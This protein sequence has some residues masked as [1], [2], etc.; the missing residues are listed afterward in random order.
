M[1]FSLDGLFGA[2]YYT[3][4][5]HNS[6]HVD[7][8]NTTSG[9]VCHIELP[10]ENVAQCVAF[11]NDVIENGFI[12][13]IVA[14]SPDHYIQRW[15]L[16]PNAL[17]G[18]SEAQP[19][20]LILKQMQI[21]SDVVS[22]CISPDKTMIVCGQIDN[23][24]RKYN[25]ENGSLMSEKY[26]GNHVFPGAIKFSLDGMRLASSN[27]D[28]S[29]IVWEP[30]TISEPIVKFNVKTDNPGGMKKN[31]AHIRCIEFDPQ[32]SDVIAVGS[33]DNSLRIWD[34]SKNERISLLRHSSEVLCCSFRKDGRKIVTGSL[35]GNIQVWDIPSGTLMQTITGN[36]SKIVTVYFKTS[37]EIISA[38]ASG[39]IITWFNPDIRKIIDSRLTGKWSTRGGKRKRRKNRK[40][41]RRKKRI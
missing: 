9:E 25:A 24:I 30:N 39:E 29:V 10:D 31:N 14:T 19:N 27:S 41:T 18:T 6:K 12:E 35:D 2:F 17:M 37:D 34:L 13:L 36:T 15:R 22:L 32:N 4:G 16:S 3:E 7:V 23:Y 40:K 28:G 1:V 11:S 5:G 21:G 33:S 26:L 20:D 8:F 38:D